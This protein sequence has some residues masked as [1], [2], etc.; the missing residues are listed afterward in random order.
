[1]S[2]IKTILYDVVDEWRAYMNKAD[3]VTGM[4]FKG[5]LLRDL[6]T[7]VV[8]TDMLELCAV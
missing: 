8:G 1:M 4:S 3:K 6:E 5:C 2:L 7:Q